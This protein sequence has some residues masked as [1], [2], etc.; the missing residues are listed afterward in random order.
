MSLGLTQP[1]TEM[2]TMNISWG[3]E[4]AGAY[5]WPYHVPIVLKSGSLKLLETSGRVQAC[6]RIALPFLV[7]SVVVTQGLLWIIDCNFCWS[8]NLLRCKIYGLICGIFW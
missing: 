6:K 3:V 5:G 1:L 2:S 8:K 7:L 4:V